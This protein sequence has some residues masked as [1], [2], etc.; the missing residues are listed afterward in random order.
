MSV[1]DR[2][3]LEIVRPAGGPGVAPE[4]LAAID[5]DDF[6]GDELTGRCRQIDA[7]FRD[8][9]LV[10]GTPERVRFPEGRRALFGI[11][12]EAGAFDAAGGDAINPYVERRP[13][14]RDALGEVDDAGARG[15][16]MRDARHAAPDIGDDVDDAAGLF[17]V[18]PVPRRCLHH[19]PGA[20]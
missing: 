14:D 17:P 20:V 2:L 8:V 19:V 10:A 7:G 3:N 12:V 16:G 1:S 4:L 9:L 15:A 13:F 18:A 5:G 11:V 6:A